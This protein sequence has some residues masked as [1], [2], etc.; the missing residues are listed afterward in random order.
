MPHTLYINHCMTHSVRH[1][2]SP[3]PP[4][5]GRKSWPS[6]SAETDTIEIAAWCG[7]QLPKSPH[8]KR[9]LP[10]NGN[11]PLPALEN[12]IRTRRISSLEQILP[13]HNPSTSLHNPSTSLHNPSTS[14][15]NPSRRLAVLPSIRSAEESFHPHGANWV[16]AGGSTGRH[17]TGDQRNQGHARDYQ[18]VGACIQRRILQVAQR[19]NQQAC[20]HQLHHAQSQTLAMRTTY[21]NGM[22]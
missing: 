11:F 17:R 7:S 13:L 6:I 9:F 21:C 15:H 10:E 22:R 19:A 20:A 14:L 16:H 5:Q 4:P 18:Q 12:A 8:S 3:K 1:P 2:A